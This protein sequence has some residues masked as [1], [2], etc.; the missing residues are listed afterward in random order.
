M[1][2]S[3]SQNMAT[4][5]SQGKF[6][7]AEA[8]K[9]SFL[10]YEANRTGDLDE[11]TNRI[12][13]REDS[14]LNDDKK[15]V[16]RDLSGDYFDADDHVKFGLPMAS[17]MTML[18]LMMR[19]MPTSYWRKRNSCMPSPKTITARIR[20]PSRTP[21]NITIPGAAIPISSHGAA[22]LHKATKVAGETDS[23]YLSNSGGN[24]LP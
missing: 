5:Q 22:W 10:F 18:A 12:P 19:P 16:G 2:H 11:Q 17:S 3:T 21:S 15:D 4:Q 6:D 9:K 14:T 7:Y 1:Q 8:L 13:W 20:T 24:G 23:T